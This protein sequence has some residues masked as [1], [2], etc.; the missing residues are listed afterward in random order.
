MSYKTL[1]ETTVG[2]VINLISNDV[3]RFD[4]TLP[5]LHYLWIGPLQ[6]IVATYFLWHKIGVASFI[7][8][9]TFLFFIPL[10]G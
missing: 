3:N 1:D 6:T 7:G 5:N 10:Q 4:L 2:Q 8:I 9:A